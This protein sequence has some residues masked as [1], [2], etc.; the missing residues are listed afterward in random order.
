VSKKL[1]DELMK[2]PSGYPR[3]E[4]AILVITERKEDVVTPLITPWT[5]E[6]MLHELFGIYNNKADINNRQKAFLATEEEKRERDAEP[7][8]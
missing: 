3:D 1:E 6:A 2:K 7:I 4:R 8:K 5:Y